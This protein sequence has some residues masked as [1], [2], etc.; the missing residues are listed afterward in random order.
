MSYDN[1]RPGRS[2]LI[3]F[4]KKTVGGQFVI[5]VYQRNYT[6]TASKEVKQYL[7]DFESVLYGD[8]QNHFLGIII[9]L[10]NVID[11]YGT[12]E[13]SVIDGQQ[14]LTT[15]FL[16]LYSIRDILIEQDKEHEVNLLETRILTNLESENGHKHKLKPLVSD[17]KVYQEII[18]QNH[19]IIENKN[20]NVFKNFCYI[21]DRFKKYISKG[22][23]TEHLLDAMD[24]LYI[25]NV[26]ISEDDN[27][28]KI[29]ESINSTGAKLTAS[30]LIRNFMLM[31]LSSDI[32]DFYY[33]K[34]WKQIENNITNDAKKLE[35]FFRFFLASKTFTLSNKSAVYRE[36]K[37]WFTSQKDESSIDIEDIFKEI[38]TYSKHFFFIYSKPTDTIS[39]A[40]KSSIKDFRKNITDMPAP[41]LMELL[42]IYQ[43]REG[44][45]SKLS[46][47]QISDIINLIN[48]YLI[49]RS[50]SSLD[51]S[52]ITRLFPKLLKNT[53]MDCKGDF[54]NIVE[55]TKKNLV[56]K[57]RGK[58]SMMPDNQQLRT[59]LDSAN[60]YNIKLTIRTVFEKI[61]NDQNSAPVNQDSL[62]IEHLMPQTATAYWLQQTDIIYYEEYDKYLNK[63][64]NLTLASKKDNSKMKNDVWEYKKQILKSTS[65]LKMNEGLLSS[66]TWTKVEINERTNELINKIIELYPYQEASEDVI[67]K[68]EIFLDYNGITA[69]GYLYEEDGSV[70]IL[71]G[72]L[73][74]NTSDPTA[75]QNLEEL[76]SELVDDGI[77]MEIE[78]QNIFKESY[79]LYSKKLKDTALSTSAS[80]LFRTSSRNGWEYWKDSNGES[81]NKDKELKKILSN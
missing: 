19:D 21:K 14:R 61:E 77:I 28:Q 4:I 24:K 42:N 26:P 3:S 10:I 5:P 35:S 43:I 65:H 18:E 8:T 74:S 60:A 59:Y 20:S 75:F 30:D 32:Q 13:F 37:N 9:Y 23:T 70:E 7:S 25:V 45:S 80:L 63:L 22:F 39:E 69:S 81:L 46:E 6:W 41:L 31:D 50:L 79:M 57:N 72:S 17:D 47:N 2:N 38:V 33:E 71:E 11:S 66:K 52:D 58:S 56:N 76:F 36:F 51:T 12:Q 1:T 64:G 53:L 16:M 54:T 78:G 27:A 29:F 73:I 67:N 48:I 62:S 15:T 44:V 68:H 40:L 49:R 55:Y 34:Y